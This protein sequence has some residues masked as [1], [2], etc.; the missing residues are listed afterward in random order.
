MSLCVVALNTSY[1]KQCNASTQTCLVFE[2]VS[3]VTVSRTT[4]IMTISCSICTPSVSKFCSLRCARSKGSVTLCVEW[5][6]R[7]KP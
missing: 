3:H 7:S 6:M 4:R 2:E 1:M 5:Y